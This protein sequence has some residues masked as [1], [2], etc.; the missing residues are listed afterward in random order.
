MESGDANRGKWTFEQVGRET[1]NSSWGG[2][3]QPHNWVGLVTAPIQLARMPRPTTP[4][5]A[6]KRDAL[7]KRQIIDDCATLPPMTRHDRGAAP[8]QQRSQR[9]NLET[10]YSTPGFHSCFPCP[11][12]HRD[13]KSPQKTPIAFSDARRTGQRIVKRHPH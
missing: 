1:T 9:G 8:P 12:G 7:I 2:L 6:W 11:Y 3:Q 4:I 5:Y 13:W 10:T